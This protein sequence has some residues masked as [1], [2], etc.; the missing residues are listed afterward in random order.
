[1]N[2]EEVFRV[3]GED[4]GHF[5]LME[6]TQ[7]KVYWK[8][9]EILKIKL[10]PQK[11]LRDGL[12]SQILSKILAFFISK[13]SLEKSSEVLKKLVNATNQNFPELINPFTCVSANS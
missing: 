4:G 13:Q 6:V 8:R 1:M 9:L 10:T 7:R 12:N 11:T 3:G 5:R 2:I